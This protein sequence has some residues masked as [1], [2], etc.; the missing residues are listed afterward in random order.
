MDVC[1]LIYNDPADLS[2]QAEILS[3]PGRLHQRR[4]A[5]A[6]LFLPGNSGQSLWLPEGLSG[7]PGLQQSG[8][9]RP[10]N[11]FF[12]RTF[13]VFPSGRG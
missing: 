2:C 3:R 7:G 8:C 13:S 4:W 6:G 9:P 11:R 1:A 12:R 10:G 5:R